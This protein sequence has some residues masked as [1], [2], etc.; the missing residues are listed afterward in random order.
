MFKKVCK[1]KK[2]MGRGDH[3]GQ[4]SQKT[5]ASLGEGSVDHVEELGICSDLPQEA[6]EAFKA[7]F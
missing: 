7:D 6:I 4:L 1:K 5:Q 2:K 3:G